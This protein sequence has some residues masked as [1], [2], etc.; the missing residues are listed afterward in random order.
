M[1]Y[2][3]R[4]SEGHIQGTDGLRDSIEEQRVAGRHL[5]GRTLVL[6]RAIEG[7]RPIC[8]VI[9]RSGSHNVFSCKM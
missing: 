1:N 9:Y 4:A 2:K 5:S 7:C 3:G 8:R 6:S